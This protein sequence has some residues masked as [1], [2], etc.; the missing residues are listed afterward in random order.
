M[1]FEDFRRLLDNLKVDNNEER[2]E[3]E[4]IYNS[5]LNSEGMMVVGY[6]IQASQINQTLLH[7]SLI[8]LKNIFNKS[9]DFLADQSNDQ[10][11]QSFLLN[12]I[13]NPSELEAI[14]LTAANLI[15]TVACLFQKNQRWE[16][17]QSDIQQRF[18]SQNIYSISIALDCLVLS[19]H[20]ELIDT[21]FVSS[22][23][24]ELYQMIWPSD[25]NNA[26]LLTIRL[27]FILA[28]NQSDCQCFPDFV[29]NFPSFICKLPYQM[30]N[31]VL[32]DLT[33]YTDII[34]NIFG[35]NFGSLFECLNSIFT[36]TQLNKGERELALE[37]IVGII[38][39]NPKE[40]HQYIETIFTSIVPVICEINDQQD[41]LDEEYEDPTPRTSAENSIL[42]I[43]QQYQDERDFLEFIY[44]IFSQLT[45]SADS[46]EKCRAGFI[47]L[48]EAIGLEFFASF[49]YDASRCQQL[50]NSIMAG[51]ELP[52]YFCQV[53]SFQL[54]S[55]SARYLCPEFQ[56]NY[57]HIFI[58]PI[59]EFIKSNLE[60]SKFALETL[61]NI[62]SGSDDK[63]IEPYSDDLYESLISI[64]ENLPIQSQV[65]DLNCISGLI[66]KTGSKMESVYSQIMPILAEIIQSGNL[67]LALPA[68][69][70]FSKVGLI[71]TSE[72]YASNAKTCID[73]ILSVKRDNL[74]DN[75]NNTINN[76]ITA[77]AM[78]LGSNFPEEFA[79][80][81]LSVI[82][83]AN[84]TVVPKELPLS[85]D[86]SD[87]ND[88]FD[89]LV[90]NEKENVLQVY[91]RHQ[92][93]EIYQSLPTLNSIL[94][95]NGELVVPYLQ[96][97]IELFAKTIS[98]YFYDKIQSETIGCLT[99]LI[100]SLFE[101][102]ETNYN[103]LSIVIDSFT[104]NI[105]NRYQN[106][107]VILQFLD[108][109]IL[110]YNCIKNFETVETSLLES[111]LLL[112]LKTNER[113]HSLDQEEEIFLMKFYL[114][115][116]KIL[117]FIT[118]CPHVNEQISQKIHLLSQQ[119]FSI[120]AET[121]PFVIPGASIFWISF[122][123]NVLHDA[124]SFDNVFQFIIS[125]L[126]SNDYNIKENLLMVLPEVIESD[127]FKEEH[128]NALVSFILEFLNSIDEADTELKKS[129]DA[130]IYVLTCLFKKNKDLV[131]N[132]DLVTLWF[133]SLPLEGKKKD[134][135]FKQVYD[136]LLELISQ[137]NDVLT[138]NLTHLLKII[139]KAV[140]GFNSSEETRNNFIEFIKSLTSNPQTQ[141]EF[142]SS[143]NELNN[144]DK[145]RIAS[146][147]EVEQEEEE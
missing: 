123:V 13:D 81:M 52:V 104:E 138:H 111:L 53:A 5:L 3:A 56:K 48:K 119:E 87:F 35:E 80:I 144:K 83:V 95:E 94:L 108:L 34:P 2:A 79:Q 73:F 90:T 27:I 145:E 6:L 127:L 43:C 51:I 41:I 89:I 128:F 120:S 28:K 60:T 102:Q 55:E 46:P 1:E 137:N 107:E 9:P 64:F 142:E 85:T 78:I 11:I 134:P 18:G 39:S 124:N 45:E 135:C 125:Q 63:D 121:P 47:V 136:F 26:H 58:N 17:F 105:L 68:V 126:N 99:A 133:K 116:G 8:L 113:C 69:E 33:N 93:D 65:V 25:P 75:Q 86:R 132:Q 146:L 114:Y 109:I 15:A 115:L 101:N 84:Q 97:L 103:P 19:I 66:E 54:L 32:S 37:V 88:E 143:F 14:R 110:L 139:S 130:S 118:K 131:N 40:M 100:A 59:L 42:R 71:Y 147:I 122:S 38:E 92:F 96:K 30:A 140:K 72:D 49:F 117:K 10:S 67:S 98:Y 44:S 112:V 70:A 141:K 74:D 77:F 21:R 50:V 23:I 82:G 36:N 20:K 4:E 22:L 29:T 76:A 106:I 12:L 57:N 62:I 61:S 7:F 16:S 31:K 129:V 91:N 24:D